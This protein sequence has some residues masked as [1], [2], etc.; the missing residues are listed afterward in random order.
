VPHAR[1]QE[2][3][4]L[5]KQDVPQA[6]Q[7]VWR[8]GS[9]PRCWRHHRCCNCLQPQ[10]QRSAR[11]QT[12]LRIGLPARPEVGSPVAPSPEPPRAIEQAD[13]RNTV[14]LTATATA[15]VLEA[16]LEEEMTEHLGAREAS[17]SRV[18]AANIR[19][20]TRAKTVLTDTAGEVEIAVPRDRA[21]TFE[22]VIV[23]KRQPRL[24]DVDAVAISLYAM[25]LTTGEISAHFQE[26]YRASI[27]KDTISR[28]TH[29]VVE[30]MQAWCSRPLLGVSAAVFIDAIHVKVRDG[31]SGTSRSTPR[32]G[33]T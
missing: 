23:A 26:V 1:R 27:S 12:P 21:G 2:H 9:A 18:R 28:I 20:G 19:N 8:E 6:V 24:S 10:R 30:E 13:P 5:R 16:A 7:D 32:S 3:P 11:F 15:T 31:Q 14:T 22:P 4:D 17:C 33:S 29:T 25:G